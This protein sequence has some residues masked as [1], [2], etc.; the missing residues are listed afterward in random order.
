MSIAQRRV[1][2]AVAP[3]LIAVVGLVTAAC[4]P[5]PAAPF[6]GIRFSAP[7]TGYVGKTFTP[8]ATSTSGLPV[9]L[10]LDATSTGCS[11]SGGVVSFTAPG[12]C[13]INANQPGN[14][15]VPADPQVQRKITVYNC[16]PL[17]SGRWTGPMN[18]SADVVATGSSFTG[19]V[20]LTSLGFGVQ[21]FEGTVNCE[22]ASMTFNGVPLTGTLSPDGKT[23]SSSYQGISIVLNA[24]PV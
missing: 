19:T 1:R 22:R 9:T 23:L 4:A 13:V 15:T 21:I 11:F 24:P 8:T 12:V 7:A 20:D 2:V 17:R 18:L 10:T 5:P 3:L 16:P 14:G 6:K